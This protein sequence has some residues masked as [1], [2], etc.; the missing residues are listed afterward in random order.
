M[1]SSNKSSKMILIL[2][3]SE[4]NIKLLEVAKKCGLESILADIDVN[5]PARKYAGEFWNISVLDK[6]KLLERCRVNTPRII[7]TD[8][9]DLAVKTVGFLNDRLRLNGISEKI[10]TN[11]TDKYSM[12]N[13]L[14]GLV[15]MPKYVRI[16]ASQNALIKILNSSQERLIVKP[17]TGQ[18]SRGVFLISKPEEIESAINFYKK[19]KIEDILIEQFIVGTEYTVDALTINSA[20]II[21]AIS[22]KTQYSSNILVS[23]TLIFDIE[24]DSRLWKTL[25]DAHVK[26]VLAL[27]LINGLTHGEYKINNSKAYLIEIA[28]RGGGSGISTIIAPYV[29]K[30]E[31]HQILFNS[32]LNINQ[33]QPAINSNQQYAS[34]DFFDFTPGKVVEIKQ[35][36]LPAEVIKFKLTVSLG[37]RIEHAEDDAQ[38]NSYGYFIMGCKN[39]DTLD[40]SRIYLMKNTKVVTE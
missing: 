32:L 25:E 5:C 11:F 40:L 37:E 16:N 20:T 6:E 36:A 15:D 28:A 14:F 2:G 19:N 35:P 34:L 1:M 31:T 13:A 27:G 22:R 8:S 10:A 30:V 33:V 4:W 3:G 7:F 24:R 17:I 39:I 38:R 12:R 18:S 26:S 29:S 21:T 9:T 23:K